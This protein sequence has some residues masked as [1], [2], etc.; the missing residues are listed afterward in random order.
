M[1]CYW[2]KNNRSPALL[3]P[4]FTRPPTPH[5]PPPCRPCAPAPR[6]RLSAYR[7]SFTLSAVRMSAV[8]CLGNISGA[9]QSKVLSELPNPISSA[10][11]PA[12][13][14]RTASLAPPARTAAQTTA[15]RHPFSGTAPQTTAPITLQ[16]CKS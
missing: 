7:R 5:T 14:I 16:A 3:N 9:A 8:G 12:P 11:I 2:K 6:R 15:P 10:P 4:Y 13:A 1:R